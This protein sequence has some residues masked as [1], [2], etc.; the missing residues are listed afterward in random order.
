VNPA[1]VSP[2]EHTLRPVMNRTHF[3]ELNAFVAVAERA[4][5][6]RAA[7]HLGIAASGPWKTVWGRGF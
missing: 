1:P 3:A 6:A 5:F 7:T 4:S 2:L